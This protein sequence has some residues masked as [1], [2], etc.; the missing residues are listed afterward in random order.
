MLKNKE[1]RR[2]FLLDKNNWKVE[3]LSPTIRMLTLKLSDDKEVRRIET[4]HL[5]PP[6]I[7]HWFEEFTKFY[8]T[9]GEYFG[10]EESINDLIQ[11]LTYHKKDKYIKDFELKGD[12]CNESK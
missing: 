7:K 8:Y 6:S 9:D 11:Y 3:Q 12:G 4:Q 5:I 1:E 2:K 10:C